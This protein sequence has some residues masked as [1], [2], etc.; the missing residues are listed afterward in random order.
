MASSSSCTSSTTNPLFGFHVSEKLN[1]QNYQLWCAQ[2][3]TMIRGARLEGHLNGKTVAPIS[4]DDDY[5]SVVSALAAKTEPITL[6]ETYAQLLNFENRLN[7]RY[8]DTYVPDERHLAAAASYAYGVDSNWYMDSGATDHIT[9]ELDKLTVCDK[10]KGN[11]QVHTANGAG[12][13]LR[14]EIALLPSDL[15]AHDQGGEQQSDHVLDFPNATN[16][17]D[18][19]SSS[20]DFCGTDERVDLTH[21]ATASDGVNGAGNSTP[22][23]VP[24]VTRETAQAPEQQQHGEDAQPH[25]A[26]ET[27]PSSCTSSARPVPHQTV[28]ALGHDLTGTSA[29]TSTDGVA[30]QDIEQGAEGELDLNRPRTRL[31]GGIRKPKVYTDDTEGKN[32]IDCKWVYKVKRKADGSLDRYKARLVAKGFKQRYGIDNEDTFNPVIKAA[33]IR[34]VLSIAVSRGWSLQQ[35]DVQNAFL[36]GVLEEEV[37]MRQPPGYEN[38]SKPDFICKLDKAL[39]GLKQAPR[40]W[41]ARLSGKLQQLGFKPSKAD[42]SLF[43]FNKGNVTMFILIYVDDIIVASST[44]DAVPALLHDLKEDFALK[45]LGE[46]HYFLGI[47]VNKVNNGLILTQD[48]D[49]AG[50]LDDRRSTGGFAVYLGSNLVS[51]SA[52]KQ[53]TVSRSS[54]EAEYKA[55]ANATA[56]VADGF[57][58]PL[59]VKQL[60]MFRNN[61]NLRSLD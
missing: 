39:Y 49:W 16:G 23:S 11:D 32:I 48:A 37:Y 60:E 36:H 20:T 8:D 1:K 17:L 56:E 15:V 47:E 43:Y 22:G 53:A 27:F 19:S 14:A 2:V 10:Y 7:L 50:C 41:Y 58:K 24:D 52:R 57:T 4:Y 61:L 26:S 30:V 40:A 55:L 33:T 35:L 42:T 45:D 12:A 28:P 29:D 21:S 44:K 9:N 54:T 34:T 46:L 31:Q 13:Q 18:D 51:W 3:L 25:S 59:A 5:D 38:S 6:S